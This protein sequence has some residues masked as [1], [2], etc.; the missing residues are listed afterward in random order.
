MPLADEQNGAIRLPE[1]ISPLV[2]PPPLA[3]DLT[4][5]LDISGITNKEGGKAQAGE[6][7]QAIEAAVRTR[8]KDQ[9]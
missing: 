1:Y 3:V 6:V 2:P 7:R 9:K 8:N 5:T 4:Y